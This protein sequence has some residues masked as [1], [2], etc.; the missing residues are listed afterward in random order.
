MG[1]NTHGLE[2]S[3]GDDLGLD[4]T[5]GCCDEPMAAMDRAHGYRDYTCDGCATVLTVAPS[6]LVFDITG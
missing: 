6:G 5:P 2:L 4:T 3:I 1:P